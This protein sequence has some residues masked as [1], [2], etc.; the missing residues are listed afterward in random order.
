MREYVAC[1]IQL[2]CV[3]KYILPAHKAAHTHYKREN[4]T[5]VH[6]ETLLFHFQDENDGV[7]EI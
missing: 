2:V 3:I 7:R 4:Y 6:L 5:A 1:L